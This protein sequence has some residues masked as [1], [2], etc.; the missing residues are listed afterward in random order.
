MWRSLGA[1]ALHIHRRWEQNSKLHT[2]DGCSRLPTLFHSLFTLT[3]EHTPAKN[4]NPMNQTWFKAPMEFPTKG[5]KWSNF[6][7]HLQNMVRENVWSHESN[8]LKMKTARTKQSVENEHRKNKQQHICNPKWW[9]LIFVY[10]YYNNLSV[11]EQ[12]L[13][14]GGFGVRQVGQRLLSMPTLPWSISCLIMRMMERNGYLHSKKQK[15]P[16][17]REQIN[18][19]DPFGEN[20]RRRRRPLLP[21]P[22]HTRIRSVGLHKAQD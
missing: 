5:Q 9:I 17:W 2:P 13:E 3:L 22:Q 18:E 16:F 20:G 6:A 8:P 7:T 19:K 15:D 10:F 4:K 21:M 11:A 1:A 12:C 14:R